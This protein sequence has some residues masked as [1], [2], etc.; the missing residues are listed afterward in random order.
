[1]HQFL[2]E[3]GIE[4]QM[5]VL[6]PIMSLFLNIVPLDLSHKHFTGF[7]EQGWNYFYKLFMVFLNQIS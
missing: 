7:F 5:I 1:M 3:K 6:E 4:M 2:E